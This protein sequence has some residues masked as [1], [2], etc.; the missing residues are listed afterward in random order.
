MSKIK[1]IHNP[2]AGLGSYTKKELVEIVESAGY[3][4]DYSSSKEDDWEKIKADTDMIIVAGGDGTVRKLVKAFLKDD[5]M[6]KEI[7]IGLLNMGTA[8]NITGTL[9]IKGEPGELIE[10]FQKDKVKK[11]DIGI[12]KGMHGNPFF[13]ESCG[14]GIFPELMN[15]MKKADLH[16]MDAALQVLSQIV[17]SIK[18]E[19]CSIDID[20][21]ELEGHFIL[22]EI[23]NC[24]WMGPSL[25]MNSVSDPGDGKL[26]LV[27]IKADE[28]DQ[29][30]E[31]ITGKLN[32]GSGAFSHN[33]L[34]G[35]KITI[36]TEATWFHADDELIKPEESDSIKAQLLKEHLYF[37]VQGK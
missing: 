25:H 29:F 7:P 27:L 8:N 24:P 6:D 13:L 15:H 12:V 26:E 19:Y 16:D 18:A 2:S 5:Q 34:Q 37:M 14:I 28:R 30:A 33:P 35:E 17:H 32:G 10:G 31:F 21:R 20:G 23:M 4:C 9:R 22:A 11:F 3:T 36:K 1:L